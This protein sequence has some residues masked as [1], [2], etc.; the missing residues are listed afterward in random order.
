MMK[1]N[2]IILLLSLITIQSYAVNDRTLEIYRN[3]VSFFHANTMTSDK[4]EWWLNE[5]DGVALNDLKKGSID[6]MSD[7]FHVV[8]LKDD[9]IVNIVNE[10]LNIDNGIYQISL[11]FASHTPHF[12]MLLQGSTIKIYR[13]GSW[14]WLMRELLDLY[15]TPESSITKD[16][17]I[18]VI[19]KLVYKY[20]KDIFSLVPIIES[21]GNVKYYRD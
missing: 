4:I 1:R 16:V 8:D 11:I 20:G 7:L 21:Y 14:D 12:Y 15:E 9:H 6:L 18:R 13:E 5:S 2:F 10:D 3:V 19:D 17:I